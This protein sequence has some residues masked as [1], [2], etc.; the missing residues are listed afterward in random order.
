MTRASLGFAFV[1]CVVVTTSCAEQLDIPTA[2]TF[3]EALGSYTAPTAEITSN[4]MGAVADDLLELRE[5]LEDSEVFDE[6]LD[7]IASVQVELEENTDENGNLF[8]P[9]LGTFPQPNAVLEIDH[10]CGGWD[11]EASS[12]DVRGAVR[13]NMV[14][15]LGNIRPVVW[16]EARECRFLASAE[17]RTFRSSYD[18]QVWL[19][20]GQEP[21]PTGEPLRDL[22]I[23]FVLTGTLGVGDSE[24]D[25]ERSFRL[26]DGGR[27]L[28][29]LWLLENGATFV[30]LFNLESLAQGI[31]D[32]NCT[33]DLGCSCSLEEQQCTLPSGSISW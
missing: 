19:D 13:L 24:L 33:G 31:R 23:T 30:Y 11:A 25:I 7:V 28:E 2:P 26:R 14:L 4:I 29:I 17:E 20:F 18:G 27:Q 21:I 1:S 5:Q 9:G 3:D 22:V 8:I 10:R 15:E 32:A 6:I 12:D 16:G